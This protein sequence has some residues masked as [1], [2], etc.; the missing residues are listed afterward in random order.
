MAAGARD[1]DAAARAGRTRSIVGFAAGGALLIAGSVTGI[2]AASKV[3][4]L[5]HE[6]PAHQCDVTRRGALASSDV[7]ANVANIAIPLGLLG[8]GYGV[9]EWLMLPSSS[10]L[11]INESRLAVEPNATGVVVRG[12]L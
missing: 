5:E 2:L 10:A 3:D 8:I 9:Y 6:C 4:R 7:L 12:R 1:S 11:P